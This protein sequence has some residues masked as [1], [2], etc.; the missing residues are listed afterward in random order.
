MRPQHGRIGT[1]W[2]VEC[3]AL[4]GELARAEAW[5]ARATAYANDLGLMAEQAD[6][7]RNELLGNFPQAFS[8]VGL[9]KR[10]MAPDRGR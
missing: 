8:H 1:Y 4:G 6:P 7:D 9:I 10:R 2:L 5:F 3:L